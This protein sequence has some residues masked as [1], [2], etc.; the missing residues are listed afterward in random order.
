M[1]NYSVKDTYYYDLLEIDPSSTSDDIK[2][3]YKK[4]SIKY[5]PDKCNDVNENKKFITITEAKEILLD[6]RKRKLYDYLGA[7]FLDNKERK[8]DII[9][10]NCEVTISVSPRDISLE[11]NKEVEYEQIN[12]KTGKSKIMFLYVVITVKDLINKKIN[13][14]NNGHIS[15]DLVSNLI[16]HINEIDYNGYIRANSDYCA[17]RTNTDYC[18]NRANSNYCANVDYSEYDLLY[19]MNIKLYQLFFGFKIIIP[20]IDDTDLIVHYLREDDEIDVTIKIDNKG[21]ENQGNLYIKLNLDIK[22]AVETFRQFNENDKLNLKKFFIYLDKEEY[23]KE[24]QK[25]SQKEYQKEC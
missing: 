2:K 6:E 23:Q 5:H 10:P 19:N 1:I 12:Y 24:S 16:V 4:L 21:L 9:P 25:E 8:S 14:P 3:A 13:Y 18:A 15:G 11:K 7:K 20:F 17:N 22:T